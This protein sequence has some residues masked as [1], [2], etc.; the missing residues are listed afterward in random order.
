MVSLSTSLSIDLSLSLSQNTYHCP[1]LTFLS[2]DG[3]MVIVNWNCRKSKLMDKGKLHVVVLELGRMRD[4]DDLVVTVVILLYVRVYIISTPAAQPWHIFWTRVLHTWV[5]VQ[6]L[7]PPTHQFQSKSCA[8]NP[9]GINGKSWYQG[10]GV[11]WN[12]SLNL[13][14]MEKHVQ[15]GLNFHFLSLLSQW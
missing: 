3:G 12:Q 10:N 7:F 9:W 15:W 14:K 5:S 8:A 6:H 11:T 4:L 1:E 2:Y 13:R